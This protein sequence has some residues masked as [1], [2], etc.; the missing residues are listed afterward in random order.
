MVFVDQL[1]D[2]AVV[3]RLRVWSANADYWD[4]RRALTKNGKA[5]LE[6]AGLSIPFPQ[7]DLHIKD[8]PPERLRKTAA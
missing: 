3:L 8:A 1:G 6:A 2:S 7:R 5:A 4:L